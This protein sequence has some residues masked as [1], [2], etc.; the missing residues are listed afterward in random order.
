MLRR[1]TNP[2][3]GSA[4]KLSLKSESGKE[5][6]VQIGYPRDW[7]NYTPPDNDQGVPVIYLTDGNSVFLTALEALHRRLGIEEPPFAVGIIVAIGYPI[8]AGSPKVFNNARRIWDLTPPAPGS[9]DTEGGADEFIEFIN[10][11]VKPFVRQRLADTRGAKVGR[12]A[13]YG[14]SFGGLFTLHTLF[15]HPTTF[16]CF[17]ASSPSIWW[18]DEFLLKEEAGF[19]KNQGSSS[20]SPKPSLILSIGGQEKNPPQRRGEPDED[21]EKR[22]ERHNGW[23]MVDNVHDMYARLE[24]SET[25]RYVTSHVYEGEDHGTVSACSLSRGMATFFEDWPFQR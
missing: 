20:H 14:H 9:K 25:L 8:P 16:D 13:L 18:N 12:E 21:Y 17:I 22:R 2:S 15:T 19:R 11:R 24:P 3:I 5:Y 7:E 10:D 4:E 23:H 6:I 1:I